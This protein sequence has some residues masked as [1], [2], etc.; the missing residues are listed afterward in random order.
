MDTGPVLTTLIVL[1]G[2]VS[3]FIVG[4]LGE[5]WIHRLMHRGVV[6]ARIHGEHHAEG[7]GQGVLRE[8]RDYA[9]G[10]LGAPVVVAPIDVFFVTGGSFSIGCLIGGLAHA[11]FAAWSHQAQHEDPRLLVWMRRTPVHYVHHRR[12]QAKWNFGISVD[13]WDRVFGTYKPE[14]DWQS[15]LDPGAPR[16]PFWKL[17]W[18]FRPHEDRPALPGARQNRS[19]I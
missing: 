4:T 17:D 13:W 6:L 7:T 5:Y 1:D 14:P 10:T 16:R 2:I 3:G 8:V 15:L 19:K 11:I 12:A 18:R 9:L